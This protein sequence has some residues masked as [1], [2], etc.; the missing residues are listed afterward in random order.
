M[1]SQY[2]SGLRIILLSPPQ[3]FNVAD[4][5]YKLFV[6]FIFLFWTFLYSILQHPNI[7]RCTGQYVEAIPY[8]LVFEF[9]DL[10]ST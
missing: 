6:V 1:F 8:L 4:H 5:K 7:L 10:V 2:I 3:V 9:C